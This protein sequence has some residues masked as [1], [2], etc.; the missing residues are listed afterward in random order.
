MTAADWDQQARNK[1]K[2]GC[3]TA[4]FFLWKQQ[5]HSICFDDS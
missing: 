5:L 4:V 3:L 1:T 2:K